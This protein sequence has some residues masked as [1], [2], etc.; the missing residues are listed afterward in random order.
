G[1][2]WRSAS[3]AAGSGAGSGVAGAAGDAAGAADV[4]GAGASSFLHASSATKTTAALNPEVRVEECMFAQYPNRPSPHQGDA[5]SR[6]PGGRPGH[7]DAWA[8]VA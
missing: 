1:A 8:S 5:S 6:V 3:D 2:A 4:A 7:L